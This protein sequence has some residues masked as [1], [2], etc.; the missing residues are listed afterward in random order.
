MCVFLSHGCPVVGLDLPVVFAM[1]QVLT[2]L[3]GS[4]I[5]CGGSPIVL[6]GV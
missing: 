1:D 6:L 2:F 3:L 4:F 5:V